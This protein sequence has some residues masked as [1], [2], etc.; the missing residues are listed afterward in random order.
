MRTVIVSQ[1]GTV[2]IAEVGKPAVGPYQVLVRNEVAALCNA[3]DGKLVSGH[4]PG[5]EEVNRRGISLPYFTTDVPELVDQYI[6]AFEK[7]WA[8]RKNLAKA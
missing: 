3:T 1:P 8:H 6:A 4:F 5:V 2:E 7:V